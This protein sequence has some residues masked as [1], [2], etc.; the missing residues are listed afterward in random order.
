MVGLPFALTGQT[1]RLGR[2]PANEIVLRDQTVSR[3]HVRFDRRGSGWTVTD[4]GSLNGSHVNGQRLEPNVET[5]LAPG[6]L[7]QVGD[8][9]ISFEAS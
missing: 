7:L 4:L 2:D 5:P 8:V 3:N 1:V 6:A 9:V